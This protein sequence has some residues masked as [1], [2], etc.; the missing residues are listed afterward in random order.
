MKTSIKTKIA[1]VFTLIL[2]SG[3]IVPPTTFAA[4]EQPLKKEALLP[5]KRII[6]KGNVELTLCQRKSIGI[7]Y[8]DDNLGSV[9]VT[10]TGQKISITG[11]S[12]EPAKIIVYVDDFYRIEGADH[13][14]IK[15]D[16]QLKTPF[17][18]VI[19]KDNAKAEIDSETKGLYTHIADHTQLILSGSTDNHIINMGITPKLTINHFAALT[20]SV[21]SKESQMAEQE[22]AK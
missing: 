9:K 6:V 19:L 2:L 13:A 11:T 16:G 12:K 21:V 14:T 4:G 5:F 18:Q 7:R 17:L 1:A 10:Q 15:T 8:S 22:I 20:T 3:A